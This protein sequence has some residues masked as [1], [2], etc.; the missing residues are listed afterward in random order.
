MLKLLGIV[1]VT[2][3][4]EAA[5]AAVFAKSQVE[6]LEAVASRSAASI[7]A[8]QT[9][10]A[11]IQAEIA[12]AASAELQEAAEARLVK[13]LRQLEVETARAATA[14]QALATA[15]AESAAASSAASATSV[16][17]LGRMGVALG[18]TAVAA[19]ILFA[20]MSSV[21][22]AAASD[23]EMKKYA[24]GLGLTHDEMKKLKDVTV[25]WG[26]VTKATFQ[27]LAERAGLSVT[28]ISTAWTKTWS[29]IGNVAKTT[30][31]GLLAA[32]GGFV[33]FA[34]S[35]FR[36]LGKIIANVFS[37]AANASIAS[38]EFLI[39]KVISGV[40]AMAAGANA[41]I[42]RLPAK[43][44]DALGIQNFGMLD[45]VALGR[46]TKQFDLSN[47]FID[48]RNQA[49]K[50]FKDVMGGFDRIGALATKNAKA[51]MDEQ[52]AQI[53]ADRNAKKGA[54]EKEDANA[55]ELAQ[56]EQ[57]IRGLWR[58][59]EAYQISDVAAL[60]AEARLKAEEKA[61]KN[62]GDAEVYYA[63]EL[64][65]AVAQRAADGAK[66]IADLRAEGAARAFVNDL[67]AQGH[68][69]VEQMGLVMADQMKRRQLEAALAVAE[70]RGWVIEAGRLR[71]EL[72]NL[73]EAQRNLNNELAREAALKETAKK[74]DEIAK[75]RLE[76]E[77]IGASNRERA[78]RLAQLEAE[79][80][81][82][83]QS[84]DPNSAE[85]TD[86]AQRYRDAAIEAE[87]LR[88]KQAAYNIEL[89][90]TGEMLKLIADNTQVLGTILAD[91]FGSFGE[92]IGGLMGSLDAYKAKEREIYDWKV[93]ALKEVQAGSKA[94]ADIEAQAAKKSATAQIQAI[95]GALA[96]AKGLF[97][98][99]S[100]GYKLI[101]TLEKA[102]AVLQIANTIRAIA[103]DAT[104]TASSVANSAARGSADMASGAAKI[105]SQ[106]GVWAFPVVGAMIALLVG[107]GLRGGGGGGAAM[108]D[109]RDVQAAQGTG[110]VLGSPNEKSESIANSLQLMAQNSVKGI[111]QSADMLRSLRKIES[112]MGNLAASVAKSLSVSGGF[113]DLDT[114]GLG[115]KT[116]GIKGLF[117]S[118]TT[119][120][121]YDQ[122]ININ[123]ATLGQILERG[124]TGST[125]NVIE[126]IKKSSGFLG[127]GG[128]TKTSYST[129]TGTLD[130]DITRQFQLIIED[131]SSSIVTAGK[132]L[133]FDV[134]EALKTFQVQIGQISF[135][136][137]SADEIQKT[138][139]A[140]FSKVAD[141]MASFAVDSIAQFQQAGE[142]LYETL[143]RVAKDFVTVGAAL[144]S[145]GLI[146]PASIAAREALITLAG[147][148]EEFTAQANFYFENYL[149]G[150]EQTAFLQD[151]VNAAFLAMGVSTPTTIE[152]FKALVAAQD[153]NTEAGQAMYTQLMAIAPAF[154][155]LETAAQQAA[156]A[157]AAA[158]A[159]LA[160]QKT[161]LQ[162]D[163]LNAQGKS[164]E[165]LAMKRK[166]ELDAMDA[167]LRGLQ[168]QVW[169]AQDVAAAKDVL[170]QAYKRESAE[171]QQTADKFNRFADDLRNFRA[172]LFSDDIA[173]SYRSAMIKLLEQGGLAA[174]GDEGA[175]GGGLKNAANSFLDVAKQNA[176]SLLDIQKARALVART[177]DSAIEGAE[178]KATI[179]QQ[180][181]DQMKTQVGALVDINESVM[182]VAQAIAE[183]QKLIAP[184]AGGGAGGGGGTRPPR[185]P[186][187]RRNKDDDDREPRTPRE[188]E[189]NDRILRN[190]ETQS[191]T[192]GKM[193][194]VFDRADRNGALAVVTDPDSPLDTSG[195]EL[196]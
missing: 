178:G 191:V 143:M 94:A 108:P 115:T 5:S 189:Q 40:N 133:G 26:D 87:S 126:K 105:F 145:I 151:Q 71:T 14:S 39:N 98:E 34:A 33:E 86:M 146:A 8:R 29:F 65:L 2:T 162:I 131:I 21:K 82:K 155:E 53:I 172:S 111:D 11:L 13:V 30:I 128:S 51:R 120:S 176:G 52:A 49:N 114:M 161:Q 41:I 54:K 36:N 75:L 129:K 122:G 119:K 174:A 100:A 127:I 173:T 31:A 47:P 107:L 180:Q 17:S 1:K 19:G 77:L 101:S 185:V 142:G 139:E 16:T 50:T 157:A 169:K 125:Y 6:A 194:R 102:Y 149:T 99:K 117:G 136:D 60:K 110:T 192:L 32:F 167:S 27:V 109:I 193:A 144:D 148:L 12:G 10:I 171:L 23:D 135:K 106:L 25:T 35:I 132:A 59:A 121:L 79:Q 168:Q 164:S 141:Q 64:Q 160:K 138:L 177:V 85:S 123:S 83:A 43:M 9:Q 96:A 175:L 15:Q 22:D 24:E 37:A 61:L 150:A 104:H 147:G 181:L 153:L 66:V 92:A 63:A 183:L 118:S 152:Q 48:M 62:K 93:A 58:L 57:Q 196:A 159:A 73:T 28:D 72:S 188:R 56:T 70:E 67:V 55:K 88:E 44:R 190:L 69:R 170:L 7:A 137:M 89:G 45:P 20:A 38:V 68:I 42:D 158:A 154:Y 18:V 156:A 182:T 187:D 112:D 4:A 165:A 163:L 103:M 184:P 95:G 80:F 130:S 124:I 3:D 90:S 81:M 179:A 74:D 46:I 186:R 97:K 84:I 134:A 195:V 113:F 76:A 91:A 116:S 140:V 166:M 78:V